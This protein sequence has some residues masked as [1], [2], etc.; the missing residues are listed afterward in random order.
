MKKE[1]G[2]IKYIG[3][4]APKVLQMGELVKEFGRFLDSFQAFNEEH[5]MCILSGMSF[6]FDRILMMKDR[7][8]NEK[9][10]ILKNIQAVHN[11]PLKDDINFLAAGKAASKAVPDKRK[12]SCRDM[13]A[14]YK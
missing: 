5:V 10:D 9:G 1:I 2:F 13:L 3:V 4:S 12:R 11:N 8:E 7:I 6:P 14:K